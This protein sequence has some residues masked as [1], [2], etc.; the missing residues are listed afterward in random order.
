MDGYKMMYSKKTLSRFQK[1]KFAKVMKKA[2]SVGEVGNFK[3][4]DIMR[5]YLKVKDNKI[6]DISFQTYGCVAAIA[7]TD[8][9]CELV[10]GKTLDQALKL[11][12]KDVIKSLGEM[13]LIK[14]HCSIMGL[15]A[16]K[17]AIEEYRKKQ[18]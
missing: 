3:C 11:Q 13:P 6:K 16:L 18:E 1:P 4:G 15:D 12:Y 5:V 14:H 7:S 17:K 2:D 9:I 8:A 10:K